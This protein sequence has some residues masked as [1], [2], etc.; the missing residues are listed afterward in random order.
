MNKLVSICFLLPS[1]AI[2]TLAMAEVK[3]T[4][5]VFEVI[6]VQQKNG[7]SKIEWV[8]AKSIIPGDRVGYRINIKNNGNEPA[9]NI[10]LNNPV[11]DNTI[12][13]ADSARGANSVI[14]YSVDG[15]EQYGQPEQLFIKKDGKTLPAT[16][17]DYTHVRWTLIEALG[18]NQETSVQYVVQVK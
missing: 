3:V 14:D 16:A 2:S 13:V 6:E 15:G 17:K 8:E 12:Y 5:N 7:T 18:I 1:L 9:D 10:V 4:S 11:P